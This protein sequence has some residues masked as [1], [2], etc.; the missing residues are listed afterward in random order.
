M[1][2]ETH[3]WLNQCFVENMLRKSEDDNS[4]QVID[5]FSNPVVSK[6]E[7]YTSDL[8]R[9][10][11]EFS[12]DQGDR[13]IIEKKSIIIKPLPFEGIRRQLTTVTF[14]RE[15]SMMSDTLVK[16]NKLLGPKH[17]ISGKC[18]YVQ[19][20]HP[21]LLAMEDLTPLGYRLADRMTGLDLA[22]SILTLRT[23]A[24]FHATTVAVC[25]KVIH[26]V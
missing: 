19:N 11:V 9:T 24:R 4:I 8:M 2:A 26:H 16:M 20:E 12:R 17:R 3:S 13:K 25:E 10:T 1:A 15:I 5:M 7:N 23:L 14:F 21:V 18:L 6:G 22:H